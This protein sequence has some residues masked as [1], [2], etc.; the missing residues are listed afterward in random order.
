MSG[1]TGM[2]R[3]VEARRTAR[4]R[5]WQSMRILRRFTLPELVATAE[6]GDSNCLKYTRG[7]CAAGIVRLLAARE[8]GVKGGHA[9]WMLVRD[10]GPKSPRL[11]ADGTTFDPNAN[12]VLQGGV[13]HTR[14]KKAT[15]E[16]V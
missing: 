1:K 9:Q 13:C 14:Y 3:T 8:S 12:A 10:L 15:G 5:I 2:H 7:L 4:D 16:A 11:R 6:T